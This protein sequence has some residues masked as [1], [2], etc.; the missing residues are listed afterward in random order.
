M[1]RD[2]LAERLNSLVDGSMPGSNWRGVVQ[3]A[4]TIS[5]QKRRTR[6]QRRLLASLICVVGAVAAI[7]SFVTSRSERP[8]FSGFDLRGTPVSLAAKSHAGVATYLLGTSGQ[9]ALY[10]EKR[11]K[12][13]PCYGVGLREQLAIIVRSCPPRNAFPTRADPEL[14]FIAPGPATRQRMTLVG[15]VINGVSSVDFSSAQGKMIAHGHVVHNIFGITVP[16]V[17]GLLAFRDS[18][19]N[20][21]SL[22]TIR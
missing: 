8:R 13:R 2:A 22:K 10:L 3:R 15:L 11:L 9:Y 14:V 7:T 20:L 6:R 4:E 18:R 16:T 5:R 19:G 21:V 1:T 17:A 12:G